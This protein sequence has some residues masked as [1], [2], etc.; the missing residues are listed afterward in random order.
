MTSFK[1]Q[2]AAKEWLKSFGVDD[3]PLGDAPTNWLELAKNSKHTN[4]VSPATAAPLVKPLQVPV[5]SYQPIKT[6]PSLLNPKAQYLTAKSL[7]SEAP[8]LESLKSAIESFNGCSLKKTASNTVFGEGNPNKG[9]MLI[10]E[11]P[12]ADEDLQG[13]PFVGMS[14]QLLSKALSCI[15]IS[16][17]EDYYITN[18]I[19]WR[20]PGNRQPSS[21][22]I[23]ACLPFIEKHI[24]LVNPKILAF[25]GGTSAK[26]LL[27]TN[28]GVNKLRNREIYYE[29]P[30]SRKKI[31]ALV[32]YH[33]AYLLRSPSKK[34]NFWNDLLTLKKLLY[35]LTLN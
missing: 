14:G 6:I 34:E 1:N 19:P 17:R 9:L 32:L 2:K 12:G 10:G 26:T 27:K 25:I 5:S 3:T 35:T 8:T 4:Q 20:P 15:G 7:A 24:E 16:S 31:R 11:A 18:T 23:E 33:P 22:E 21:T 28:Q 13:K 30:L 29:S